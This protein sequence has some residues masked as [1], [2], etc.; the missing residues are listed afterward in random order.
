MVRTRP[1]ESQQKLRVSLPRKRVTLTT[2]FGGPFRQR[3]QS[4][5]LLAIHVAKP[6]DHGLALEDRFCFRA[7]RYFH[8]YGWCLDQAGSVSERGKHSDVRFI[9]LPTP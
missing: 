9:R 6:V 3:P 7:A 4:F 8:E 1:R 5:I 2:G